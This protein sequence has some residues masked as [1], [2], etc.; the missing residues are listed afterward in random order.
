M[1]SALNIPEHAL[2]AWLDLQ[3]AA[4]R[5]TPCQSVHAD[6]WH[7]TSAEQEW[8]TGHCLECPAM[9]ACLTYAHTAD[10]REGVWGGTTPT[11]RAQQRRKENR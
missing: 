4:A 10:E 6:R 8:A 1:S 2:T 11:D 9:T 3:D 5:G 7:G